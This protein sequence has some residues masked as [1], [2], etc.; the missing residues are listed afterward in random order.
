[1]LHYETKFIIA[2]FYM[3]FQFSIQTEIHNT[4]LDIYNAKQELLLYEYRKNYTDIFV[5]DSMFIQ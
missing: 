2:Q 1:M 3:I 4:S 5:N